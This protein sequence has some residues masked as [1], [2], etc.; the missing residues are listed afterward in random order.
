M[1]AGIQAISCPYVEHAFRLSGMERVEEVPGFEEGH[2]IIQDE[3]S[4]LPVMVSGIRPG[5]S[6]MDVCSS[7]GGKALHAADLLGGTGKVSARDVSEYKLQR[8]RENVQRLKVSNIEIKLWDGRTAD[9]EWEKRADVVIVDVPCSG[10]GVIGRKPEIRYTA[11]QNVPELQRLQREILRGAVKALKPGGTLI[12]STCTVNPAENEENARWI[13]EELSL[14]LVSLDEDL[15][16]VLRN[17]M[18]GQ[19]ML[20]ILPGIHEGNGFFVAKFIK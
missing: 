16:E 7:P 18:T 4:M 13:A 2:F 9:P 17:K 11:V 14:Q 12:Y 8:I 19:G 3:S 20:Q 10:I 6:V 1:K 5:D 15:P